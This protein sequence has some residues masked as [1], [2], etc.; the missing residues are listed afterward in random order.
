MRSQ[1]PLPKRG[2]PRADITALEALVLTFACGGAVL[3]AMTTFGWT[4]GSAA[5]V[6]PTPVAHSELLPSATPLPYP[7]ESASESAG[8]SV[9]EPLVLPATDPPPP[10][11][12]F[13]AHPNPTPRPTPELP[14]AAPF[15]ESCDGPGRMNILL[16]GVDTRTSDYSRATRSDAIGVLGINFGDR[17]AQLLS[18]PRDLYVSVPGLEAQ[19]V[20]QGRINIAYSYGELYGYPGGGPALMTDSVAQNFGLRIDRYVVINFSAFE[21]AVDAIGGIDIDVP[22]AIYDPKYP[23]DVRGQTMVVSIPAGPVHMDGATAL[24]YARTR[25]QD[26]DFGRMRRQ[27]QVLMAVRDKLL[28]PEVLPHLPSLAQVVFTS[29]RTDMSLA[30]VGLVG[31]VGPRI[32]EEAITRVVIDATMTNDVTFPD[33]AKVL[34]PRM[35]MILPVLE[36]FNTGQ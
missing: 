36:A 25:H 21:N 22:R 17:T 35:E 20:R 19:N 14:P 32:P 34:E 6:A 10:T 29:V 27:Q 28:S 15:P 23:T 3:V 31:C 9:I 11:E 5:G 13:A 18:I 33:G 12:Y 2:I 16:I 30:D 1:R 8:A 4:P 26:S 7:P 24:I